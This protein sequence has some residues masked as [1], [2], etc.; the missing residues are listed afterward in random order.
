[1]RYPGGGELIGI[2]I[3]VFQWEIAETRGEGIFAIVVRYT[4]RSLE[5][6]LECCIPMDFWKAKY[7]RIVL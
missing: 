7:E 4:E 2:V 5:V 1:M 3:Y 6:Y